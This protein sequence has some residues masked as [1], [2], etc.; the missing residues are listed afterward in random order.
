MKVNSIPIARPT[1]WYDGFCASWYTIAGPVWRVGCLWLGAWPA[2]VGCR[3]ACCSDCS[4]GGMLKYANVGV[5]PI[6]IS[7]CGMVGGGICLHCRHSVR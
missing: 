2:S 3:A 6:A 1:D 4:L 5:C 7:S